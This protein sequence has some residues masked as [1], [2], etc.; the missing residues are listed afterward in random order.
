MGGFA[1][2]SGLAHY[3][4]VAATACQEHT[5][6]RDVFAGWHSAIPKLPMQAGTNMECCNWHEHLFFVHRK[7]CSNDLNMHIAVMQQEMK[8]QQRLN[9]DSTNTAGSIT[10]EHEIA[11][12]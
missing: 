5:H 7:L 8:H 1:G 11:Y 6:I 3:N 2:Q 9:Q 4:L 10:H 12:V